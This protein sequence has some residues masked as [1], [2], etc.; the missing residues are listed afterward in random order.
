M[1]N[2]SHSRLRC[3]GDC[4]AKF[5][6]R[7]ID[8]APEAP[9]PMFEDGSEL[10]R[11]FEEYSLHC[12]NVGLARDHAKARMMS[13]RYDVKRIRE[14]VLGMAD[15]IT[16][17]RD[18]VY[19]E[20]DA[21]E[22]KFDV[23]MPNGDRFR[24]RIDLVEYDP[25][26]DSGEG[27]W[28]LTDYSGGWPA[29]DGSLR[30]RTQLLLY[31]T[32]WNE[33]HPCRH[34]KLQECYPESG[35]PPLE[36]ITSVAELSWDWVLDL[37]EQI[38]ATEEFEARPSQRNCQACGYIGQCPMWQ[39]TITL[40][41][42]VEKP[43]PINSKVAVTV[44]EWYALQTVQIERIRNHLKTYTQEHG[45]IELPSGES[46]GWFKKEGGGVTWNKQK[47]RQDDAAKRIEFFNALP[48]H[49]KAKVIDVGKPMLTKLLG[50]TYDIAEAKIENP[51]ID[52]AD[53]MRGLLDFVQPVEAKPSFGVRKGE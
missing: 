37:I 20:G 4:P 14:A 24:G 32:A 46:I 33:L 51:F 48:D 42:I 26:F 1:T 13:Q 45:P 3:F 15:N 34:W 12:Y 36:Y 22:Q 18:L 5:K 28:E 52:D 17:R 38:D 40:E 30:K 29:S 21:I 41:D 8:K 43:T 2:W 27:R 11:C 9:V 16:L 47:S 6:L 35:L 49:L 39:A 23:P 44:G 10:H 53:P 25:A 7:Y 31:A 50:D 19:T